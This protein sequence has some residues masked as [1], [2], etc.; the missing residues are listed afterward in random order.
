MQPFFKTGDIFVI[1]KVSSE[2]L[3][4]GDIISYYSDWGETGITHRLIKKVPYRTGYLLYTR[5]DACLNLE[6]P[7]EE[8]A[9][10]GKAV[11][12]I[13]NNHIISLVGQKWYFINRLI[14]LVAPLVIWGVRII[15][16]C[17]SRIKRLMR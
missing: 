13:R 10:L 11:A 3:K 4:I 6:G 8:K 2:D 16:P 1:K 12:A 17:Y 7:I 15:R 14:V 9:L 5:G